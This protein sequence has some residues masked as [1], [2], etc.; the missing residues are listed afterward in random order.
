MATDL[1]KAREWRLQNG[2]Y[3]RLHRTVLEGLGPQTL[4]LSVNERYWTDAKVAEFAAQVRQETLREVAEKCLGWPK[5]NC[6]SQASEAEARIEGG[7]P[8]SS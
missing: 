4:T 2:E 8:A 7:K 5:P 1:E 3:P 6:I